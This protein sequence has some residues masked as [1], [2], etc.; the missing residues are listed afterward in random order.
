MLSYSNFLKARINK[1]V[2]IM[3]NVKL[4]ESDTAKYITW[5]STYMRELQKV[6]NKWKRGYY[7]SDIHAAY[8]Q[9]RSNP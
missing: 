2:D 5:I 9:E 8:R 1:Y 6:K 4:C 3:K 7:N